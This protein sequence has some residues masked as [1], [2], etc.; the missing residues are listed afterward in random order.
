MSLDDDRQLPFDGLVVAT[1]VTPRRLPVGHELEGVHVLRSEQDAV[2]L[3][4]SLRSKPRLVVVGAG[5]LGTEVAAVARGMGLEVTV[6]DPLPAPLMRQFGSAVAARIAR[7]HTDHGVELR[8][9]VSVVD[10]IGAGG[11][12]AGIVLDDGSRID[13]GCVLVAVGATPDIGWLGSAGLP[14]GNGIECDAYCQAAPG[15]YSAGDVASWP[16]PRFGRRMRLEHRMNA[17]EQ[18]VV[19]A[20]N[21]LRG[22]V[23]V[24]DPV[25][26]FWT[27]QYDV[28]IQMYGIHPVGAGVDVI[29]GSLTD[30]RF[31]VRYTDA[32]R[33]VGVLA[34]NSPK[35]MREV[36]QQLFDNSIPG[37][38]R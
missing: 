34:W 36:R 11:R 28:K 12:V 26:Y 15:V 29:D 27:D 38:M 37:R 18:G 32:D 31:V 13:A 33:T 24:F 22:N 6:V 14:L 21:L 9:G 4:A 20:R 16:S 25:P 5:F 2:R 35:R 10:V 1:G 17:T 7:L 3:R 30:D 23:E 19:A 8:C